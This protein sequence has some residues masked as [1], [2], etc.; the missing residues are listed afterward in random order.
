MYFFS[1]HKHF[2]LKTVLLLKSFEEAMLLFFRIRWWIESK[3]IAFVWNIFDTLY[4]SLQSLLIHLPY[5]H[6]RKVYIFTPNFWMV[7]YIRTFLR[8]RRLFWL[9]YLSCRIY[10][11]HFFECILYS[12]ALSQC[13]FDFRRLI[14]N[15]FNLCHF[16]AHGWCYDSRPCYIWRE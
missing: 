7:V 9:R 10:S 2:L 16:S 1:V 6:W 11:P 8:H 3:K 15:G 14:W 13:W 5:S 4:M 12:V